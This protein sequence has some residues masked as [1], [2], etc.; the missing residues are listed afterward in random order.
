MSC[1]NPW[2]SANIKLQSVV[3][4]I[5][6]ASSMERLQELSSGRNNPRGVGSAGQAA[7]SCQN[8]RTGKSLEWN[9]ASP[10]LNDS[11]TIVGRDRTFCRSDRRIGCLH[12]ESAPPRAGNHRSTGYIPGI[13][14]RIAEIVIAEAGTDMSRFPNQYHFGLPQKMWTRRA[15][16][17]Y[18]L[19]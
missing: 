13:N 19:V 6:G 12:R 18:W 1:R 16:R 2:K 5:T 15:Q 7:P 3:T 9:L 17:D 11:R 10:S 8:P 14:R 4:D